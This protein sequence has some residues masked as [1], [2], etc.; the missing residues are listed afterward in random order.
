MQSNAAKCWRWPGSVR[1]L[2]NLR[3]IDHQRSA[4]ISLPRSSAP[5]RQHTL[6][7][8]APAFGA[9]LFSSPAVLLG[10][11]PSVTTSHNLTER[12]PLRADL[13]SRQRRRN[14]PLRRNGDLRRTLGR[15]DIPQGYPPSAPPDASLRDRRDRRDNSDRAF[16]VRGKSLLRSIN[17][18]PRRRTYQ[19]NNIP[20]EPRN[21]ARNFMNA[22]PPAPAPARSKKSSAGL[23]LMET[24]RLASGRCGPAFISRPQNEI[25]YPQRPA[26]PF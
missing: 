3:Y 6:I 2:T 21:P 10:T 19:E 12:T 8:T 5:P 14:L 25:S 13:R 11:D 24:L 16:S 22:C 1:L 9:V 23:C 15:N 4:V 7:L 18:P 20:K 26:G 17:S